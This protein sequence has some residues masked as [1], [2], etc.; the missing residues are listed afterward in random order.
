M[1]IIIQTC[2]EKTSHVTQICHE[3]IL[4]ETLTRCDKTIHAIRLST[5]PSFSFGRNLSLIIQYNFTILYSHF[6]LAFKSVSQ[7]KIN[8]SKRLLL[9]IQ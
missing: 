3:H 9:V 6:L 5:K 8:T 7:I 2:H 1:L 4:H